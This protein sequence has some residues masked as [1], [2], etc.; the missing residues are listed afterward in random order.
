MDLREID[1]AELYREGMRRAGRPQRPAGYWD[2]R[3]PSM[4]QSAFDS[5]YV[6]RFVERMDLGGCRTLLD[7]GCGPGTIGLSVASRLEHVYGLDYSAGMLSAFS[8]NARLRGFDCATPIL[9]SW[10]EDWTDVPLCD[11][12]V[13]SRS[14]AVPDM[15]AALLKLDSKARLRVYLTYPAGGH[16]GADEVC[17][18]IGRPVSPLPDYLCVVGILH[19]LGLHPTLDYLPGENRFASC[20]SFDE[21]RAKVIDIVGPVDHAEEVRLKDYFAA[22]REDLAREPM[23]W[24]FFSW[25]AREKPRSG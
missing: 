24:A 19:H 23:R 5:E 8:E 7:V 21:F 4:S 11:V 22:H 1:F 10:D 9:R 17:R 25:Q 15:E 12:V 20:V 14:T 18:A 16:F 2:D 6:R 13:A 3:A